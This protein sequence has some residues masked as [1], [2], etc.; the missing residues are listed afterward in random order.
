MTFEDYLRAE[1]ARTGA[2]EFRVAASFPVAADDKD[3]IIFFIYPRDDDGDTRWFR[4]EGNS[5]EFR[6]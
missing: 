4:V 2:V 3:P 1:H 5:L 6:A